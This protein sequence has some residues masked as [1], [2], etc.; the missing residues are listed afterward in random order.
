MHLIVGLGN[1]GAKY[2]GNRH[3]VGMMAIDAI[4][5]HHNFT[6]FKSKFRGIYADGTISGTRTF[7]LKPE[8]F[9][10]KSGDS[11]VDL[12]S[13]FKIPVEQVSVIYDE[14]DL[15]QGKLRVKRGGGTGGH[16]GLRSIDP[17]IGKEYKRVRVGIGHPGDKSLVSNYVLSDFTKADQNWLDPM[18]QAIAASA[19]LLVKDDAGLFMNRVAVALNPQHTETKS[20]K[21]PTNNASEKP[22]A[23]EQ[24]PPNDKSKSGP[25]AEMLNK[26]FGDKK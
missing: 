15:V 3:N 22:P 5:R 25:M 1:P 20:V 7:L 12:C 17:Q 18:L 6:P 4:A 14:L 11:V 13:F 2:A 8:T 19:H 9:M 16:N 10:N 23:T 21:K 26:L 24:K